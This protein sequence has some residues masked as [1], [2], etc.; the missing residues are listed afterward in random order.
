MTAIN[1]VT[2]VCLVLFTAGVVYVCVNI[3]RKNRS[4]RISFIRG[5]KK[6]KCVA[7]FISAIPLLCLGYVYDGIE[8]FESILT[9]ISHAIGLVVLKF[10]LDDIQTLIDANL[11][12]RITVYYCCVLVTFN[13]ILF[14]F[15][16]LQQK[17]W[18]WVRHIASKCTKKDKLYILGCNDNS[19]AIY[20]SDKT[21][22]KC[23]AD[24]ISDDECASLYIEN[25]NHVYCKSFDSLVN[26]FF[27][28][29]FK[30]KKCVFFC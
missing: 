22:F 14:T 3:F 23:I 17:V 10:G 18:H 1:I 30:K 12:Y 26:E 24:D 13:A 4:Q 8:I 9:A 6:G 2:A 29:L 21:R 27:D 20:K 7:I 25:I 19:K 28:K 5:F 11:F 16:L 15:S